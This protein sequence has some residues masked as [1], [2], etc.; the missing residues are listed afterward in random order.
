MKYKL[1]VYTIHEL[2]QRDNQEDS[3]FPAK[4]EENEN[5]RLFVLCDGMGG[6]EAG[7]VASKT[8]CDSMSRFIL[9]NYEPDGDFTNEDLQKAVDAAFEALDG[10]E[11]EE[12]QQK[13]KMGTTMTCLKL[14][15][16]GYTIAH[17]GDSRV[18]HIRPTEAG[19]E[20]LFVTRDHSL[21][22]DLIAIN[23]LT[24]EEAKQSKQKNII[25]RAMQPDMERQPKPDFY[26]SADIKAG[27]YFYLCSDGMLEEMDDDNICYQFSDKMDGDA[28]KKP[29]NLIEATKHNQDNHSAI[30]VHIL[31]VIQELN[32][33]ETEQS[34]IIEN[35]SSEEKNED[36]KTSMV[37]VKDEGRET[38]PNDVEKPKISTRKKTSFSKMPEMNTKRMLSIIIVLLTLLLLICIYN[39]FI[40]SCKGNHKIGNNIELQIK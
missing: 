38:A 20:I 15:S 29:G 34:S 33:K 32:E 3:I 19:A 26:N 25:T 1:K 28:D 27:D 24:P 31:D 5:D 36:N 22:N 40:Y 8:V 12:T 6:H 17:M 18:Y 13:R 10:L 14:H 21:I 30:I 37:E 9:K 23:E 4:D 35:N 2:G 11:P 16:K 39:I 7:E